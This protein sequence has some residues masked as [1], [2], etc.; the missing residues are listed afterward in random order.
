MLRIERHP[1][2]T[3]ATPCTWVFFH[4]CDDV[5][6]VIAPC[7]VPPHGEISSGD[8]A[9]EVEDGASHLE[10][11]LRGLPALLNEAPPLVGGALRLRRRQAELLELLAH[12]GGVVGEAREALG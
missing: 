12:A 3:T 8:L 6:R 2:A 11:T 1:T 5:A 10:R 4:P 7:I 9:K